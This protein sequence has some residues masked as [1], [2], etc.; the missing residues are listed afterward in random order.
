MPLPATAVA[1]PGVIPTGVRGSRPAPTAIPG[2]P[3]NPVG[4]L[5][6][7]HGP[8]LPITPRAILRKPG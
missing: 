1:G 4:R 7:R 8:R 2:H 6:L 5:A 3:G